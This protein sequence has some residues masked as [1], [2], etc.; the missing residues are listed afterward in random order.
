[1]VVAFTD[2]VK[3]NL[4]VYETLICKLLKYKVKLIPLWD[5]LTNKCLTVLSMD[6]YNS[7]SYLKSHSIKKGCYV[8]CR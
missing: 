5:K 3:S 8:R 1:M 2:Q 6:A 7:D 4:D